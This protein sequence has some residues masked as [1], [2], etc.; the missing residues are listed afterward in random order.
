MNE[1]IRDDGDIS[2]RA[3]LSGLDQLLRL[4]TETEIESEQDWE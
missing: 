3:C 1:V 4:K 2:A